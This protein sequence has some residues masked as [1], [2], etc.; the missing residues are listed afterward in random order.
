MNS[1]KGQPSEWVKIMATETTIKGLISDIHKQLIQLNIR[2]TNSSIQRW[3]ED[4]NRYFS[5][6]DIQMANK[7][8]K[9]S[10]NMM[11]STKKKKKEK[12]LLNFLLD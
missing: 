3:A 11:I 1:I 8:M 9:I 6:G 5:K 7:H 4:L 2:K 10:H 12:N